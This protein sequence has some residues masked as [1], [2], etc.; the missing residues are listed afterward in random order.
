MRLESHE[1]PEQRNTY[2]RWEMTAEG[3]IGTKVAHAIRV[4]RSGQHGILNSLVG[5]DICATQSMS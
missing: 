3:H 2:P 4:W 5:V 1:N